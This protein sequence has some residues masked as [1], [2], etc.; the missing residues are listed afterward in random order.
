MNVNK[1]QITRLGLQDKGLTIPVQ[2]NWSLLDPENS[3]REMEAESDDQA[4][5]KGMYIE[6]NR[7]HH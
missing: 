7:M 1:V 2:W 6:T 4:A 5:G 3:I